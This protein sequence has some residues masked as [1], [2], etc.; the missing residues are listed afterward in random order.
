[1]NDVTK[2][3]D[4]PSLEQAGAASGSPLFSAAQVLPFLGAL[5]VRITAQLGGTEIS[6]GEL[7]ELRAGATLKLDRLVDQPVDLLVEGHV[8][9]QG[10][11]VAAGDHFG[12][13]ITQAPKAA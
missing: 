12:V 7:S 10:T 5:K 1:M 8:V 6:V 11:L 9:A 3:I 4:L 13:R 2:G